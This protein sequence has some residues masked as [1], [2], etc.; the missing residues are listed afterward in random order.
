MEL[1]YGRAVA[2]SVDSGWVSS[3][4]ETRV[5]VWLIGALE[6]RRT[7]KMKEE[8]DEYESEFDED[9]LRFGTWRKVHHTGNRMC[10]G[11][12]T[13]RFLLC[14]SSRVRAD[15][16]FFPHSRRT[17]TMERRHQRKDQVT[18]CFIFLNFFNCYSV[19]EGV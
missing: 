1:L 14:L 10:G 3:S 18:S 17:F 8:E 13:F 12:G 2:C 4:I 19:A 7:K 16:S 9:Y 15:F 11:R 6:P 5:R